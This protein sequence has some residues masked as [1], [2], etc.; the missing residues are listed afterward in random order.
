MA[1]RRRRGNTEVSVDLL[2]NMHAVIVESQ[3]R[4][5][6]GKRLYRCEHVQNVEVQL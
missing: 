3:F 4:S 6:Y 2:D 1:S 5:T